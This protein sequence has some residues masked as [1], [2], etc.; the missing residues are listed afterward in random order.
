M[1]P[2]ENRLKKELDIRELFQKGKNVFGSLVGARYRR[3]NLASSRFAI[4]VGTKVHKRAF[5]RNRIRR[6]IR[7]VLRSRI[8]HIRGGF[9]IALMAKPGCV[10]ATFV[11]LESSVLETLSKIDVIDRT[12]R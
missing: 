5:R 3:N 12:R 7:S 10:N 8:Q 9:D 1:L 11:E 6:R 4:V 2:R